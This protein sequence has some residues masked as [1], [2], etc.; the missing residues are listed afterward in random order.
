MSTPPATGIVWPSRRSGAPGVVAEALDHHPDLA[1]GVR[2][3][4]AGVAGLHRRQVAGALL[5]RVGEAAQ[6][7]RALGRARPRARP[8]RPPS[9]SRRRRRPRRRRRAGSS[10]I[11]SSVA[12]SM[13]SI[14]VSVVIR[15]PSP[16][17]RR[18]QRADHR[19]VAA[20]LL[21]VPEDAERVLRAVRELDRLDRLVADRPAR[22]DQAL[23]E[24]VDALVVMGLDASAARRRPPA[25]RASR[26]RGA[27]R[28]RRRRPGCACGRCGRR[29]RAGAGRSV[30]PS[31]TFSSCMPRQ[32][33]STGSPRSSAPRATAI[34]KASRSG[35]VVW[36][37]GCALGAVGGRGRC[38]SRRRGS[39]RRCGRAAGR[40]RRPSTRRAA[41][42][43]RRRPA[44]W[45]AAA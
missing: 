12:G 7:R 45:T 9:P 26:A 41:A 11:T 25:P 43:A 38:R 22:R 44:P 30:P 24:P 16:R 1:L 28:G 37:S 39:G 13:T 42:A 18:D 27:P 32:M 35:Q 19:V 40:G 5:D 31:A 3:R 2:D 21:G 8:G 14:V 29:R 20:V 15:A 6:E 10:A 23:A 33:P 36:V 4:L 34:S 17:G